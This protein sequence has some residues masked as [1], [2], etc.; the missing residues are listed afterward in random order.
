VSSIELLLAL[1]ASPNQADQYGYT[2]LHEAA[3]LGFRNVVDILIS[4]RADINARDINGISPLGYAM[5]SGNQDTIEL[6]QSL[7]AV[8]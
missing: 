4:A 7:G 6:L 3:S 2:A 5:R 8:Q 1:G